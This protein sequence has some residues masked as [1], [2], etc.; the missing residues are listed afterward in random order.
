MAE[1]LRAGRMIHDKRDIGGILS[2]GFFQRY[3]KEL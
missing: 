2:A 3:A 1:H